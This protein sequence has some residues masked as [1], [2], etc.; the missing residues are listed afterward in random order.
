[1]STSYSQIIERLFFNS[2]TEGAREVQFERSDIERAAA[3]LGIPLPKN[4]G[5]VVYSFRYRATLPESIRAKAPEGEIWIIRPAGRALYKFVAIPD[6]PLTPNVILAQ[7]KISDATRG[8]VV[9][10]SLNDEQALL[11]KIRYNRLI[12]IFTGITCYSLQNHLRT[13]VVEMG[14]VETDEVYVGI[15]R[16]GVQYVLPIQAKRKTD[17]LNIVQIEQDFAVCTQKFPDLLCRAIA[18]Q[19]I[20]DNTIVLFGFE[21]NEDGVSRTDEKHYRLVGPD[22]V[23][24]DDLRAYR[25]RLN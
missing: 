1:M 4:L 14:Q 12:D 19:F 21:Q 6:H 22:E 9:R 8:I 20:D 24:V 3:D 16:R 11:V 13:T 18:A 10:Y 2:Y 7:K 23:T 17:K 15:D 5:D 25:D